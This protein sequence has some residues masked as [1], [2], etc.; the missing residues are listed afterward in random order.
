MHP[1]EP[2][3]G[4]LA[5]ASLSAAGFDGHC[6]LLANGS[7]Y[8]W[9][10]NDNGQVDPSAPDAGCV[11]PCVS[12]PLRRFP[13]TSFA[14][15]SAGR[16]V[17]CAITA[18][19]GNVWCW[20]ASPQ[21]PTLDASTRSIPGPYTH[22]S[23]GGAGTAGCGTYQSLVCAL[24]RL[25]KAYCW[26]S[27]NCRGEFGNGPDAGTGAVPTIFP[28]EVSGG[29]TWKTISVGGWGACATDSAGTAFC[30]GLRSTNVAPSPSSID[31]FP[32]AIALPVGKIVV[33]VRD[34]TFS[35]CAL[36]T[37]GEVYCWGSNRFGALGQGT[38]DT[39]DHATPVLV[40]GLPPIRTISVNGFGTCALSFTNERWCWG[41]NGYGR[42][43]NG[44]AADVPTPTKMP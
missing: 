41:H 13:D 2:A 19:A 24:D 37:N 12:S 26:G 11:V 28:T 25:G 15:I 22:V 42:F 20:G 39:E 1:M 14:E 30:W 38:I 35:R 10:H 4:G 5:F 29:H 27:D 44:S 40:R 43:G 36:T 6:G 32:V 3:A 23:A 34:G 8:C 21:Q 7:A 18:D 16:D 17:T 9:G 33:D 31:Y